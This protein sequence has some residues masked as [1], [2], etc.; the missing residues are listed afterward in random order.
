MRLHLLRNSMSYIEQI[1]QVAEEALQVENQALRQENV[2]LKIAADK[3]K[4]ILAKTANEIVTA[5]GV[6]WIE[7]EKLAE[8]KLLHS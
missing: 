2:T 8:N 3:W 7:A 5:Q 4:A 1:P 6:A